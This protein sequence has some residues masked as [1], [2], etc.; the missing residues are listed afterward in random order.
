MN[1]ISFSK[2]ENDS[3]ILVDMGEID[4]QTYQMEMIFTSDGI[5]RNLITNGDII[6]TDIEY[7]DDIYFNLNPDE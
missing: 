4:G 6:G 3:R 2:D 7:S 5:V 1:V